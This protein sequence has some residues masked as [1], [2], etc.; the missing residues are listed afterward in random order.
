MYKKI[1]ILTNL[2]FP[3]VGGSEIVVK[4]ILE[5]LNKKFKH[6]VVVIA[7]N[8]REVEKINNVLYFPA[9]KIF[10]DS[11][12]N[13]IENINNLNLTHLMVYS[14]NCV[15]WEFIL[16]NADKINASKSVNLLGASKTKKDGYY[17]KLFS[18]RRDMFK[19]C[20]HSKNYDD[21]HLCDSM[22]IRYDVIPN[23]VDLNEM[24]PTLSR[25]EFNKKY[26]IKEK[27]SL[28]FVA[29][30]FPGKGHENI[31]PIGNSLKHMKADF[32]I[33]IVA[34][35]TSVGV[36]NELMF[37]SIDFFQKSRLPI[38]L[39]LNMPRQDVINSYFS[40][41][42]FI[43]PSLKEVFSVSIL[44]AMASSLPWVSFDTGNVKEMP[45]GIVVDCEK[46]K[47]GFIKVDNN[48][49]IK[50]C[51][52]TLNVINK[53]ENCNIDLAKKEIENTFNW[54]NISNMYN[55]FFN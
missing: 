48:A 6:E 36:A 32:S 52:N 39:L 50:F 16:L 19:V 18:E 37:K 24:K 42:C 4:N 3:H 40:S 27:N 30:F 46:D 31:V 20:V 38:K 33:N 54:D 49:I 10:S 1:G 12:G 53:K 35:N 11:T 55:S 43:F 28:L 25:A 45:G 23:G 2:S 7:G 26:N 47:N 14:D 34:S 51:V 17:R 41:D 21:A 5:N 22:D 13:I 44:E 8:I 29:N 9:S 15:Q